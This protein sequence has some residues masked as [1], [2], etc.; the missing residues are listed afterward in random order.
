MFGS[1]TR[2][3]LLMVPGAELPRPLSNSKGFYS[4]DGQSVTLKTSLSLF[5]GRF[6]Y[7]VRFGASAGEI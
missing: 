2:V 5:W 4:T 3:S 1:G 6:V 7:P